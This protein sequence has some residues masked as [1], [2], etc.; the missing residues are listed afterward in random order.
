MAGIAATCSAMR[1]RI[2]TW[3]FLLGRQKNKVENFLDLERGTWMEILLQLDSLLLPAQDPEH[4]LPWMFVRPGG[5]LERTHFNVDVSLKTHDPEHFPALD[6]CEA[7]RFLG[8]G[9]L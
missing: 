9:P 1:S 5:F 4:F 6:V 2:S 8:E 7:W 3:M